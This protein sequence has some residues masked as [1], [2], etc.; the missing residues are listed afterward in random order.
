MT[1][2]ADTLEQDRA[3]SVTKWLKWAV[4]ALGAA[5]IVLAMVW[6]TR[7]VARHEAAH[8]VRSSI[9]VVDIEQAVSAERADYL[10]LMG[11]ENATEQEKAAATEFVKTSTR[12]INTALAD[13][14]EE[15]GCVLL[16]RPAVLQHQKIGL[17]DHTPRLMELLANSNAENQSRTQG[18]GK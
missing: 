12:R 9:G 18:A 4:A 6:G 2:A 15:C 8:A 14:A 3:K 1:Q 16:I 13:I 5:V 10:R 7:A 17:V 11:R